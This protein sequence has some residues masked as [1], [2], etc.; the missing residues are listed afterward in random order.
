M[1]RRR[2]SSNNNSNFL[3]SYT[4]QQQPIVASL[5]SAPSVTSGNVLPMHILNLQQPFYSAAVKNESEED[6]Q[7]RHRKLFYAA[8][9]G[10]V[11]MVTYTI[12]REWT[13][14][15]ASTSN[16]VISWNEYW[17]LPNS[18]MQ[19]IELDYSFI[20]A[21]PSSTSS[22]TY[23]GKFVVRRKTTTAEGITVVAVGTPVT[24]YTTYDTPT[25][26]T[27]VASSQWTAGLVCDTTVGPLRICGRAEIKMALN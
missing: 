25:V 7:E 1:V 19:T 10:G 8:S 21:K 16:G 3:M 17:K 2:R 27:W 6:F 20:T 14:E 11:G 12:D 13:I 22:K 5:V 4:V 15:T 24:N 18:T 23:N 9:A 26:N